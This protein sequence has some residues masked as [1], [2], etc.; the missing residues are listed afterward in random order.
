MFIYII[1]IDDNMLDANNIGNIDNNKDNID[2]IGNRVSEKKNFTLSEVEKKIILTLAKKGEMSGYDLHTKESVV[3]VSHWLDVKK[4]LLE[5]E[6]I[7]LI[8]KKEDE[9]RGRRKDLYWLTND[10]VMIAYVFGVDIK[11]LEER[12][13]QI[14]K[15]LNDDMKIF[16]EL[17]KQ[18]SRDKVLVIYNLWLGNMRGDVYAVAVSEFRKQI[19]HVPKKEFNII[20]RIIKKYPNS[21]SYLVIKEL[22]RQFST[23]RI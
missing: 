4:K 19:D 2:K 5:H 14:I 1:F 23:L 6:L 16:Y 21:L 9:M 3:S 17:A 12:Q 18:L 8:E 7:M 20:I 11:L 13:K 15:K 22:K 10:G